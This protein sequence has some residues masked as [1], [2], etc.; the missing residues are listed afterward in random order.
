MQELQEEAISNV[1]EKL[2][3][4]F[5]FIGLTFLVSFIIRPLFTVGVKGFSPLIVVAALARFIC[6]SFSELYI[7][8]GFFC[9]NLQIYFL[10]K[11]LIQSN[12]SV[13]LIIHTSGIY[14]AF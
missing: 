13:T 8:R 14:S 1:N 9:E 7:Y 11:K 3:Q 12:L 10:K 6:A 5:A 4:V 2:I